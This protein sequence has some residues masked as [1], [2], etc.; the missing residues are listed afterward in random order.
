MKYLAFATRDAEIN[1]AEYMSGGFT[2]NVPI[3]ETNDHRLE[4]K[5]DVTNIGPS[6][7]HIDRNTDIN[8]YEVDLEIS[9]PYYNSYENY[10]KVHSER[11]LFIPIE[12]T[13]LGDFLDNHILTKLKFI[14]LSNAMLMREIGRVKEDH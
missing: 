9:V 10:K 12:K 6:I 7:Y 14:H 5:C 11:K 13:V 1:F 2:F 8:G 4:I 3:L